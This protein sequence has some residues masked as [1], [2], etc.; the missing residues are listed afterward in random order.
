MIKVINYQFKIPEGANVINTTSRSKDFGRGL[1]PFLSCGIDYWAL[2]N[3]PNI[4]VGHAYVLAM[5]LEKL[6]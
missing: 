2:W 3:N 4:K 5:M 6:I 1:S